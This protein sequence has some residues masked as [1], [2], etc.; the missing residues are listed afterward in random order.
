MKKNY[1]IILLLSLSIQSTNFLQASDKKLV[2]MSAKNN[3]GYLAENFLGMMKNSFSSDVFVETGTFLG[4]S[5][6]TAANFYEDAHTIELSEKLAKNAK[7]FLENKKNIT[8]HQGDSVNVFEKLLP[9][10]KGKIIFWLDGHYSGVHAGHQTALSD[11]NTLLFELDKIKKYGKTNS[12]LMIDDIRLCEPEISKMEDPIIGGYPTILKICEKIKQLNN[13]YKFVVMGDVLIAY[14]NNNIQVSPVLQ[15]C[16]FSR[17]YNNDISDDFLL[18]QEAIISDAKDKELD[19]ITL[20]NNSFGSDAHAVIYGVA[21]H[22]ILWYGLTCLANNKFAKALE[23]F[24]HIES[25]GFNHWRIYLYMAQ[26][27]YGLNKLSQAENLLKKI[28]HKITD[29]IIKNVILENSKIFIKQC[30]N[31]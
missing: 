1:Y 6:S 31:K 4:I 29:N 20:L 28:S 17:L 7:L 11:N 10:L 13:D 21:K 18:A 16:T 15:A 26:A 22:Y 14:V 19:A 30:L 2:F 8:V 3:E 25:L 27:L 23:L 24:R 12:V 9:T 5:T